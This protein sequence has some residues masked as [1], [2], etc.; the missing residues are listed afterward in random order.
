MPLFLFEPDQRRF[1]RAFV[2][3][4]VACAWLMAR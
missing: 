1:T 2:A 3:F 4:A